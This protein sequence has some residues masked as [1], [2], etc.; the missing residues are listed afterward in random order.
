[1]VFVLLY[2]LWHQNTVEVSLNV[3]DEIQDLEITLSFRVLA[4]KCVVSPGHVVVEHLLGQHELPAE[5]TGCLDTIKLSHFNP[6][7]LNIF[8]FQNSLAQEI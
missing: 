3:V 8:H 2:I 4:E 1:M 7:P 6:R 5:L